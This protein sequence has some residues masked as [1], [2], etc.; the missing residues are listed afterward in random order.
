MNPYALL[1]AVA[2]AIGSFFYGTHVG[3]NNELAEQIKTR[4]AILAT[5]ELAQQGAAEAIAHNRPVHT[6]IQ[7][8][9]ETI[10]RENK[11]LTECVNPPELKQLL[12]NARRDGQPA[13][14]TGEGK[15]PA[16]SGGSQP[17]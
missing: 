15:L 7:Q 5:R 10:I 3:K 1:V 2:V 13:V 12:D 16:G 11:I 8:R 6:T 4:T 9:A 17:P 14:N